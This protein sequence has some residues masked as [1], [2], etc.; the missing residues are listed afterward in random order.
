MKIVL[1][2]AEVNQ[3]IVDYLVSQ[4]K[5]ES[6]ETYLTWQLDQWHVEKPIIIIEQ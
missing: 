6:K 2:A 1:T 4:R 3:I 5:I